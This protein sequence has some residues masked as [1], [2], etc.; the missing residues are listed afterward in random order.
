M[1]PLD[2]ADVEASRRLGWEA[3]GFPST[4]VDEA[5]ESFPPGMRLFGAFDSHGVLAARMADRDYDSYFGGSTV[6]TC[7]I[8]G[9][10]TAA[11]HR[12]VGLLTPLFRE[13]LRAARTRGAAIS[14][15]F[16]TAPRIYRRFGYEI[17][18]DYVSVEVP[19]AS[20]AA[21][22]A[23]GRLRVR[24]AGPADYDEVRRVYAEWAVAQNGPLTR[25]GASFTATADDFIGS[26]SGVTLAVDEQDHVH[27]YASW[28]RGR[29]YGETARID[30]ADLIATSMEAWRALVAVL[31]SFASVATTTR[32]DTSGPDLLRLL[33]PS[34]S[35]QVVDD[36][37]YMLRLLDLPLAFGGRGFAP[38]IEAQLRFELRDE[39]L[40]ELSGSWLLEIS[41]GTAR[42]SRSD[43]P[44]GVGPVFEG[45]GL[46]LM[47]AGAQSA[48]NL[49]MAGLMGG[50]AT[51]DRSWDNAFGGRQFHIRDYF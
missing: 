51:D 45:R 47:Y 36:S 21:V 43:V 22:P 16:P 26:F 46:S 17:V 27:G 18:G 31:G 3:F 19:T 42:C 39:F 30:V 25:S 29:G 13:T 12:G 1:R 50:E 6:P 40:D 48:A 4:P 7:G 38:G 9:V 8:A 23:E 44:D 10:T 49:R 33:L 34:A 14:T 15:L 32:L 2:T 11:E 5:P 37:P 41:G 20:L 24:R 35:W 28:S